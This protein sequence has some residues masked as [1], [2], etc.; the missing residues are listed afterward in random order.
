MNL[1]N[2]T[3]C[4]SLLS[5]N[6]QSYS[7][8][9]KTFI[10]QQFHVWCQQ[11]NVEL[12]QS[13]LKEDPSLLNSI[14]YCKTPLFNACR[15]DQIDVIAELLSYNDIKP[16][17][18]DNLGCT[19]LHCASKMN[20]LKATML[21]LTHN[22]IDVNIENDD[23]DTPL[24]CAD[25]YGGNCLIASG[26]IKDIHKKN[27]LNQTFFFK[28]YINSKNTLNITDTRFIN[29]NANDYPQENINIFTILD[30][31]KFINEE[32]LCAAT[33]HSTNHYP[34]TLGD[35]INQFL[36]L[37]VKHGADLNRR[38]KDGE[39]A[40][41]LAEKQYLYA[42]K[43]LRC[44]SLP[45]RLKESIFH[46]FLQETPYLSDIDILYLLWKK[47]NIHLDVCKIIMGYYSAL[48]I[49][50]E[51]VLYDNRKRELSDTGIYMKF[52]SNK[53][54]KRATFKENLLIEKC[55][56]LGYINPY[57]HS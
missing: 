23:E 2:I 43:N 3:L 8:D 15:Y 48:T 21:L 26:K 36:Q 55:S 34:D 13:S 7:M 32:V 52:I 30:K 37:C 29:H 14:S 38:N 53:A 39:R 18:P 19:T 27:S 57:A 47:N 35:P 9:T 17:I 5:I 50:R 20:F 6:T 31:Q 10:I 33:L 24:L 42:Q 49:D 25:I 56:F 1:K 46:S 41:D 16:N 44:N 11:G 12:I 22:D 40:I 45:F 51:I 28:Q 54:K 4:L